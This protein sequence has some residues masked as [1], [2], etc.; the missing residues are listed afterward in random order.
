MTR[1]MIRMKN[2]SIAIKEHKTLSN[3]RYGGLFGKTIKAG[4]GRMLKF[5]KVEV[6]GNKTNVVDLETPLVSSENFF[7]SGTKPAV[8]FDRPTEKE[9]PAVAVTG[10]VEIGM[11]F[12]VPMGGKLVL[13]FRDFNNKKL[14]ARE[15]K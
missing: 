10:K 13:E 7:L 12:D 4:K 1:R 9:L 11:V 6:E 5:V 14:S 3:Y 2:L 15:L 8:F